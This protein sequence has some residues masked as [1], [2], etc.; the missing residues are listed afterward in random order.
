[1][2]SKNISI[3]DEAYNKLKKLKGKN[4]SFTAVI[5]RLFST[6]TL[7]ELRGT[8]SNED[9][10]GMR[11]SIVESREARREKIEKLFERWK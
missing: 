6:I 7:L 5:N 10:N 1:M 11:N 8:I 3:S 9:A 2:P 4:E